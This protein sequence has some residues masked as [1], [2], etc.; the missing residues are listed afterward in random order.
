[1]TDAERA[2]LRALADAATS[3]PWR[4]ATEDDV[5]DNWL[6]C[7]G[8]SLDG[9]TYY[10]T[11]DH[12]HASELE[13]D[14]RN[15]AEF[16]AACRLGVPKLVDALA[17]TIH[18]AEEAEAKLAWMTADRNM[19]HAGCQQLE[20]HLAAM[21][22]RAEAAEARVL[23][24]LHANAGVA[25]VGADWLE[26]LTETQADLDVCVNLLYS[27]QHINTVSDMTRLTRIVHQV[28]QRIT[29]RKAVAERKE[30]QP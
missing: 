18:R 20:E 8:R 27:V 4:V 26:E 24:L 17:S 6:V 2:Q 28:E 15:D 23:E 25:R 22:A 19:W 10:V 29:Q 9:H 3:A 16:I 12:V 30:A 5:S 7:I 13:G 11:T 21:T 14:A 1:M